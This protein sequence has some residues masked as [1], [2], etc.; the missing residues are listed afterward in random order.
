MRCKECDAKNPE[1]ASFCGGCGEPLG[2]ENTENTFETEQTA[3]TEEQPVQ[4]EE[5]AEPKPPRDEYGETQP[6]YAKH[7]RTRR[8]EQSYAL[9]RKSRAPFILV[10]VLTALMSLI[11]FALPLQTWISYN[12]QLLGA[13]ISEGRLTLF[14]LAQRFYKNDT[15]LPLITGRT[16]NFGVESLIPESVNVQYAQGRFAVM[17]LTAVFLFSLLLWVFFII[18]VL[19]RAR[20][21][22]ATLGIFAAIL[23]GACSAA[24]MYG[25]KLVR[26]AVEQ[27]SFSWI[28]IDIKLLD[29]PYIALA[30]SALLA[31]LCVIFAI[32]GAG[33]SKRR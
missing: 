28:Y 27:E 12:Y 7:R 10:S 9:R 1:G 19:C 25:V 23:Y 33:T 14:E 29:A 18:A 5:P 3:Q 2:E 30:L 32:L 31:V 13:D 8:T 20:K 17:I 15:V 26:E 24:V 4:T 21:T 11:C 16:D 22:A 6:Y